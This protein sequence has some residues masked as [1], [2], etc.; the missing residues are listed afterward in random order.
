MLQCSR[1]GTTTFTQDPTL[2]SWA[3]CARN[4]MA[5][6][7]G[8]RSAPPPQSLHSLKVSDQPCGFI[9]KT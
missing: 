6:L 3:G 4:P 2:Q 1:D 7:L 5:L 8:K 9:T